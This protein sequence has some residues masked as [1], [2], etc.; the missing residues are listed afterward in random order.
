MSDFKVSGSKFSGQTQ[1]GNHNNMGSMP[2]NTPSTPSSGSTT[3]SGENTTFTVT[4]SSFSG[5]T[6][7]GN[8]N[9]MSTPGK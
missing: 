2:A 9:T 1:I 5:N 3:A 4:E 7:V 6:Q 8:G